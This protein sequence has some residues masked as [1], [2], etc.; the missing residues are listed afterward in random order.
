MQL[1]AHTTAAGGIGFRSGL[2]FYS[3]LSNRLRVSGELRA[4]GA[5]NG[6]GNLSLSGAA[7]VQQY[8]EAIGGFRVN[9]TGVVGARNTGWTT[10]SGASSKGGFDTGAPDLFSVAQHLKAVIDALMGHGLLGV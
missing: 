2:S 6:G 4:D 3:D 10:P 8:V 9:G 7:I 5:I 1:V